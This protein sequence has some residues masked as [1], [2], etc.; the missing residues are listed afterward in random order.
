[1]WACRLTVVVA[2]A[3]VAQVAAG[4]AWADPNP[5]A[6]TVVDELAND[7]SPPLGAA[8]SAPD[9]WPSLS[10]FPGTG[11]GDLLGPVMSF[12]GV[13]NSDNK[14]T[15]TP[16]DAE[17][18]VGPFDYVQWVNLSLSVYNKQGQQLLSPL[19]GNEVWRNFGAP[20]S[21]AQSCE[22]FNKGDPVVLYDQ[23]ENRW[24]LSQFA[25]SGTSE[26]TRKSPYVQCIA[27]SATPDPLGPY[28]RYAFEMPS[29]A[30]EMPND[31]LW[32]DEP[33]IGMWPTAYVMTDTALEWPSNVADGSDVFA[34]QRR[35]MLD[36][37]PAKALHVF[38]PGVWPLLPGDLDG[39]GEPPGGAGLRQLG[40]PLVVGLAGMHSE[41]PTEAA[42]S[43]LELWRFQL[44]FETPAGAALVGPTVILTDPFHAY[45][46][47]NDAC[48]DQ[49]DP[50]QQVAALSDRLMFRAEVRRLQDYDVLSLT[51][52]VRVDD[53]RRAGIRWYELASTDGT[54]TILRQGTY[55][56]DGDS[57]WIGS[58]AVDE[59]GNVGLGFSVAGR[60]LDPSIGFTG[61]AK[62]PSSTASR[63]S[64]LAVGGA[65]QTADFRWGDYESLTVD[66]VDDCTFWLTNEY[67]PA[68]A[69]SWYTRIGSFRFPD[70]GPQ[71]A[72]SGPVGRPPQEGDLLTAEPGEWP[73]L[74]GATF[75]YRWRRCSA[76]AAAGACQDIADGPTYRLTA[77][78]VDSRVRFVVSASS[79]RGTASALSPP[80]EVVKPLPPP[81][82]ATVDL[83]VTSV[84]PPVRAS[85]GTASSL[86]FH[87]ANGSGVTA[88]GVHVTLAASL[89]LKIL[90]TSDRGSCTP[91]AVVDCN[92]DFLPAGRTA[93]ITVT[94]TELGQGRR[95]RFTVTTSASSTQLDPN[96]ASNRVST[97]V[98]Y[99]TP[100]VLAAVAPV[101][102]AVRAKV[103]VLTARV[104]GDEA[105]MLEARVKSAAG[106]TVRLLG[107]SLVA[108][109]KLMQRA[110]VA[111]GE[112][113]RAGTFGVRLR[114]RRSAVPSGQYQI[115]LGATD[116]DG[117]HG[118]LALPFQR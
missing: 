83:V 20:G 102:V 106:R 90:A 107:G 112:I 69:K 101:G 52:T 1:M 13:R 37:L 44:N 77:A 94:A 9:G 10:A 76:E 15:M 88:T 96:P 36:G 98:T 54:F 65:A 59:A 100:P 73:K 99:V 50:A 61:I 39:P 7:T 5:S 103:V 14:N 35:R 86:V 25:W 56:P 85:P 87:V 41:D 6:P 78:D 64:R 53:P 66:P 28:H 116:A 29:D 34:F 24:L 93:T 49:T 46:C 30:F 67:Y 74:H 95:G 45:P 22:S 27:V 75:R 114:V 89:R 104:S 4:P 33:K 118:Q 70:C 91:T 16:P 17:G 63:E 82:G 11:G 48:I 117:L 8:P 43:A 32:N 68:N 60:D 80:T 2:L 26:M 3:L 19:A 40:A 81:P 57:R 109:T 97:P 105:M 113:A 111:K 55:A 47:P 108:G 110:T 31:R 58:V 21:P 42:R 23:L 18:D 71:P 84:G 115:V 79:S 12:D 92:L 51:H 62:D 38:V 72:I